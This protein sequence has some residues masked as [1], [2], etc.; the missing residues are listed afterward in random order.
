MLAWQANP[1]F[2]EPKTCSNITNMAFSASPHALT[3]VSIMS[4][5]CEHVRHPL[6]FS[7]AG[8]KDAVVT[9]LNSGF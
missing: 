5:L 7:S 9:S 8:V 6:L 2:F 4:P 3:L 1:I